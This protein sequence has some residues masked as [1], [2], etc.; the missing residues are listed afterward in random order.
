[1]ILQQLLYLSVSR[2]S[3]IFTQDTKR[4]H[5]LDR[6]TV[7][8]NANEVPSDK[9]HEDFECVTRLMIDSF[10]L[11]TSYWNTAS[12]ISP[13]IISKMFTIRLSELLNEATELL[14]FPTLIETIYVYIIKNISLHSL[15]LDTTF[16][17]Y[18]IGNLA[19]LSS[20]TLRN[21]GRV[22]GHK[23]YYCT[24]ST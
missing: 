12:I 23:H 19:D 11:T 5:L 17:L 21:S 15:I 4:M 6:C 13:C 7:N 1:M 18:F 20:T 9:I 2:N 16:T 24:I 10:I 14:N 8:R 3:I 22:T